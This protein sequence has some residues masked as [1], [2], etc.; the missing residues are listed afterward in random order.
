MIVS[1]CMARHICVETTCLWKFGC[2]GMPSYALEDKVGEKRDGRGIVAKTK[3]K[4]GRNPSE[5]TDLNFWMT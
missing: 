2:L 4:K 1:F 3:V 5:D